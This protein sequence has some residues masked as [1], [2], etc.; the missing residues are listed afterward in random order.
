M[1][2]PL[3]MPPESDTH[4]RG[5]PPS[6]VCR[7]SGTH[8]HRATRHLKQPRKPR[9]HITSS[10]LSLTEEGHRD[11]TTA[12]HAMRPSIYTHA[13]ALRLDLERCRERR[14]HNAQVTAPEHTRSTCPSQYPDAVCSTLRDGLPRQAH[15]HQRT[16]THHTHTTRTHTHHPPHTHT[17]L[18]AYGNRTEPMMDDGAPPLSP[19]V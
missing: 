8:A 17:R 4:T 7:T 13:R 19:L 3:R 18:A 2:L 12:S 15:A 6:R 16:H 1:M 10:P 5:G 14:H 9:A 11:T